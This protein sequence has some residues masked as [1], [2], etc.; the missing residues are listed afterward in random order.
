MQ[1]SLNTLG[2]ALLL[3]AIGL[4]AACGPDETNDEPDGAGGSGGS[5][6]APTAEQR[7]LDFC[8]EINVNDCETPAADCAPRC[9]DQLERFGAE[10]E[11]LAG[12]LYTCMLPFAA[13]CPDEP[14]SACEGVQKELESCIELHGCGGQVCSGGGGPEG[15]MCGC[16]ITCEGKRYETQ[17]D[18][19][20]GGAM[21]CVCLVDGAEVGTCEGV[22]VDTC[23]LEQSC[24]QEYF[25]IP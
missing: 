3:G 23:E 20:A 5:D 11:D 6:T 16:Q 13:S 15:K 2:K 19:P 17:C 12:A 25:N 8:H 21:T 14:P 7:C 4:L 9:Q 10:C 22:S 18:T 24:C 1:T